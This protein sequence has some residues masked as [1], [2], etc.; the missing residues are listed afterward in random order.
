MATT[1]QN[2]ETLMRQMATLSDETRLRLLRLLERQE[3][4]VAELCDILQMPQST[5]SRHLKILTED[6]WTVSRRSGTTNLYRMIPAELTDSAQ[7]LWKLA[8]EQT[9]GWPTLQ[10]DQ[11]RLTE[12]LRQ[13]RAG[14]QSFFEGA[15]AEWGETRHKLYGS[16]FT[17]EAIQALL[18]SSYDIADLGCGIGDITARLAGS[19]HHVYGI[20]NSPA[21][22]TAAKQQTKAFDNVTLLEGDLDNLP[23]P[24]NA[25]DAA[26]LVLVLTY[27]PNIKAALVEAARVLKPGGK[28]V[29]LDLLQHDRDDFRRQLDQ[30]H[31][32]FGLEEMKEGLMRAGF[33]RECAVALSPEPG[34]QGPALMLATGEVG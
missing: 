26:L 7:Q 24:D 8:Q 19:V 16:S 4:G 10:Q 33:V 27:L 9:D 15:A 5:V 12:R 22:I 21:M 31:A 30:H 25:V 18:P 1:P 11:I 2:P 14:V 17:Q 6:H 29:V 23:L 20:D 13:R 34:A 3:L 28:L 32:G